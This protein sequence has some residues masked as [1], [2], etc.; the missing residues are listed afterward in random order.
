[1]IDLEAKRASLVQKAA[2][3]YSR[4]MAIPPEI[5][6]DEKERTGIAVVAVVS[7]TPNVVVFSIGNP[8]DRSI[9]FATE[10]AVRSDIF[11][12]QTSQESKNLE[13]MK[14]PGSISMRIDGIIYRVSISGLKAEEDVAVAIHLLSIIIGLIPNAVRIALEGKLPDCFSDSNHYLFDL[15]RET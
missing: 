2:E 14:F 11:D 13:K 4:I 9:F 10:K 12:H 7:A 8:P 15:V 6:K 1:M 3:M 5:R